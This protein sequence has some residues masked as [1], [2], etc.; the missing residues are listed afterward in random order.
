MTL[1]QLRYFV[2]VV[3]WGSLSAAAAQVHVAQPSISQQ[4]LALE[5]ELGTEL[6]D[7]TPHGT[8]ATLAGERLYRHARTILRQVEAARHDVTEEENL[9]GTVSVGLPTNVATI[10]ALPLLIELR[11]RHP[12][13]HLQIFESLSGYLAELVARH[14]LDLSVLYIDTPAK[15]LVVE[16]LVREDL[17]LVTRR[18]VGND[19]P[20]NTIPMKDVAG[21]PLVLPS[22]THSLRTL[23][24]RSFSQISLSIRVIADVDSLPTMRRAAA[25]GVAA[26][27][28]PMAALSQE[29]EDGLL[30]VRKLIEPGI[31]RPIGLCYIETLSPMSA[32]A[33][34]AAILREQALALIASGRWQGAQVWTP[35]ERGSVA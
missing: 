29:S 8:R 15:G 23:I 30:T 22:Q 13:V 35:A 10:L 17:F 18:D 28:L 34:V 20:E 21:L 25:A 14:R 6:L 9:T 27:I 24:D 3:D 31:S 7:R 16:P 12:G 2:A 1:R 26:T 19:T 11:R 32:S 33:A 4:L 5:A